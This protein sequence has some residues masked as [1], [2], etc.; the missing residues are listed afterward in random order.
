MPMR[1]FKHSMSSKNWKII[2]HKMM[3]IEFDQFKANYS[4]EL[5]NFSNIFL[6]KFKI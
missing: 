5:N 6:N 2:N 3:L 4:I 1:N